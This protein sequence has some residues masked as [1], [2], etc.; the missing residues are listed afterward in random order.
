MTWSIK[1]PKGEPIWRSTLASRG[2]IPTTKVATETT[3]KKPITTSSSTTPS[4]ANERGVS[5]GWLAKS[6]GFACKGG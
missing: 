1:V 5:D 4:K 3:S 6:F 2:V